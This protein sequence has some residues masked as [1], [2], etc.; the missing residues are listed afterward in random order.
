MSNSM[1]ITALVTNKVLEK[2]YILGTGA[3]RPNSNKYI[4][5]DF[6]FFDS[7]NKEIHSFEE[8]DIVVLNGKF[9]F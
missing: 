4:Y 5:F 9:T 1:M 3:Y 6:K 8:G 2:N 7:G